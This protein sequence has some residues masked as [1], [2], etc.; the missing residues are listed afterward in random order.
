MIWF[1]IAHI[2]STFLEWIRIG[3][4]SDQEKDLEILILR[5]QLDILERKHKKPIRPTHAEKLTLAVLTYKLKH[6]TNRTTNQLRGIIRIFQPETVLRWHRELVKRKWTRKL[7]HKRGRP[8]MMWKFG[9]ND[10]FRFLIRDRDSKYSGMFDRVFESEGI[11]VIPTPLRASNANAYAE[12][13]VRTVREECLDHIL[14][15][16]ET[17]L[18]RVLKEYIGYY[19]ESRPHQGLDQQTPVPRPSPNA[20]RP[21]QKRQV[22]GGIINDYYRA[23][24]S[25]SSY[26][27]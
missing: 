19:E 16:N 8:Q 23:V 15:I 22:L 18:Q 1:A 5:H 2:I 20:S 25:S 12:R 27:H 21:I 14:I 9:D 11:H 3:R 10:D 17:H 4:L 6:V 7:K 13:W 26:L 24:P